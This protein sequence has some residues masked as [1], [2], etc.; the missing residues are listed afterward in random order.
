MRVN[1]YS[2]DLQYD[3][4]HN[5]IAMLGYQGSL[6]RD[7]YFHENPNAT[8][9]A[10]GYALNPQIGGGDY[11]SVLGR[12]NYN[13]MIADLK[14]QFAR[15]FSTEAQ[16][17]WSKCMD[18]SSGPYFEQPYP[19]DIGLNYG[20]CDYNV[21]KAFKLFGTWQPVLFRGNK[22]WLEKVAGGWSLS[23]ILN[24]HSGFP[25][26]PE[27]NVVGGSLYCGTCGY[28]TL[29]PANYLGGAGNSTSNDQFK[30][31][32]NYPNGGLAYFAVPTY[33]AYSGT[34]YGSALPESPGVFRN[35]LNGPDY[36]D[37]DLTLS[38]AFGLPKLPVLGENARVE[39]R[40]DAYNIFNF[41]N[42]NPNGISNN[43]SASN[44]G[45][46]TGALA[47]RVVTLGARFNF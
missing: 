25:W 22:N 27:A 3:L 37:I 23:G 40:V 32:A 16:F 2:F 30:T 39:F 13:A 5:W 35:S 20:R 43:I 24:I 6:S 44:F 21:G 17:T 33:T 41:L 28:T 29:F 1:H 11:W 47:S 4:S 15:Q 46:A 9:A 19:Y 45:Q 12:A 34:A 38:K 8:P 18:T 14:H 26:S 36:R 31:G 10:L 42:F 7:I